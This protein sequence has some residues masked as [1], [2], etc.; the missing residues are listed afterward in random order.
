MEA[1]LIRVEL[2]TELGW[3]ADRIANKLDV[4]ERTVV[5]DRKRLRDG[6][7][8]RKP[9]AQTVVNEV[10]IKAAKVLFTSKKNM[11]KRKVSVRMRAKGTK[12]SP[13]SALKCAKVAG[14]RKFALKRK[15]VLKKEHKAKRLR[16]AIKHA[17]R[18][19]TNAL[20]VDETGIVLAPKPN[21]K[22]TGQWAESSRHIAPT[23]RFKHATRINAMAGI[24]MNGRSKLVLYEKS[25]N[26]GRYADI[27]DDILPEVT[28]EFY[29]RKKWFVVQDATPLHFT[30]EVKGVFARHGV[31]FVPKLEW[32]PNSPDLNP[33]EHV[34]SILK[35]RV[36]AREPVSK[37][38]LCQY[39]SGRR[40]RKR[41][42]N[43][44]FGLSLIVFS[45]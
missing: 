3:S 35:E 34:W 12:I 24:C 39:G 5:R 30:Q 20:F 22:T 15:P 43:G 18:K 10:N 42:C 45:L 17:D 31:S 23:P 7:P 14:L 36:E 6:T 38:Q 44:A 32:P 37:A 13:S 2:L 41:L 26:G 33:I 8:G 19:W 27:L 25:M 28:G 21:S 4:G 16:F 40:F 1:R 11:S 29:K 9:R